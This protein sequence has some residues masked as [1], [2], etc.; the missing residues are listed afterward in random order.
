VTRH[1]V[2]VVFFYLTPVAGSNF[3]GENLSSNLQA[4]SCEQ[5]PVGPTRITSMSIIH[6]KILR[7]RFVFYSTFCDF[8]EVVFN[9]AIQKKL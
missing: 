3:R 5:F 1:S 2:R 9:S 4:P 6:L 7:Y 8:C